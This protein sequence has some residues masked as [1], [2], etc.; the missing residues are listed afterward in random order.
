MHENVVGLPLTDKKCIYPFYHSHAL[1][2]IIRILSPLEN[3]SHSGNWNSR[4]GTIWLMPGA[5][6]TVSPLPK[7]SRA[8]LLHLAS[9]LGPVFCRPGLAAARILRHQLREPPRPG[10][11]ATSSR[12]VP[13]I[14]FFPPTPT[15]DCRSPHPRLACIRSGAHQSRLP[16]FS[17]S[18]ETALH[19]VLPSHLKKCQ[20]NSSFNRQNISPLTL[21]ESV[22]VKEC[23]IMQGI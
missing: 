2:Y 21:L 14:T 6:Q 18:I 23:E 22:R 11:R 16:V 10:R 5:W 8:P 17:T 12:G 13:F 1:A 19:K 3:T 9:A 20:N 15:M 7:L 4:L